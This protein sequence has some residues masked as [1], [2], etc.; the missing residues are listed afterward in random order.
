VPAAHSLTHHTLD[1]PNKPLFSAKSYQIFNQGVRS[2]QKFPPL[3]PLPLSFSSVIYLITSLSFDDKVRTREMNVPRC[4]F[5]LAT[6]S[7][8]SAEIAAG[9]E[10]ESPEVP[11]AARAAEVHPPAAA[12]AVEK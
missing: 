6:I 4:I 11:A 7:A 10:V 12:R 9:T 2:P 5:L 8:I 1:L 3:G